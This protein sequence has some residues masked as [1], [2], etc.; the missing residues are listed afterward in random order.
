M[1]VEL[2]LVEQRY[3]AV[4]EVLKDGASVTEVARRFGVARQTV[5]VWLRNYASGGLGALADRSDGRGR[6][7]PPGRRDRGE[8]RLGDR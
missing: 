2:G 1:L 7:G 5:H 6:R 4:L 3:R 8:D